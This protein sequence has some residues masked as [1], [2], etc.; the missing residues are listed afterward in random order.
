MEAV[1]AAPDELARLAA[2]AIEKLLGSR[3]NAVIGLATGSSP[4]RVYDE[5]VRLHLE[6]GLS[7]ARASAFTL[8]EYVGLPPE[9]P[10]RYLN[11]IT[12]E[13]AQRVDF[14]PG[15]VRSP[16]G[17]AADIPAAAPPTKTQ[18]R[19]QAGSIC[20]SWAS[21]RTG[22]S[23]STSHALLWPHAPGSRHSPSR[24]GPTMRASSVATSPR[25][26]ITA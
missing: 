14:A 25:F 13:I 1:I 18:S 26:R 16:D 21:A 19:R 11:V 7:F 5:L 15:A 10:A 24:L 12:Q 6:A 9:H 22:T 4:L 20:R 3:P 2:G 23:A 8:D 17:L